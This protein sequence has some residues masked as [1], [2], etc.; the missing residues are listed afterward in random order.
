[1]IFFENYFF[2]YKSSHRILSIFF[3]RSFGNYA[4]KQRFVILRTFV[5]KLFLLFYLNPPF[6]SSVSNELHRHGVCNFY[7]LYPCYALSDL[8]FRTFLLQF[9]LH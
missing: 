1:M 6:V 2:I 4:I 7:V 5:K 9:S 8:V 3:P